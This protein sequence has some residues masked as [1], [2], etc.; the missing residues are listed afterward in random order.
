[1]GTVKTQA[2][3]VQ[4]KAAVSSLNPA[5]L[6]EIKELNRD[7]W[8]T[9]ERLKRLTSRPISMSGQ[10]HE[11][12]DLLMKFRELVAM[13][14][15]LEEAYGYYENATYFECSFAERAEALRRDHHRLFNSINR[16]CQIAEQ[17]WREERLASLT[18]IIPVAFDEFYADFM[19]HEG[20]E[21]E[22]LSD[23]WIKDLG[24]GD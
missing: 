14:F 24:T 16:L 8:A 4:L 10:S 17:M 5:F 20:K 2:E 13:Q 1:M 22:L 15:S 18:T 11:L 6:A 23:A 12:F 3:S 19:A 7:L 21:R 9:C